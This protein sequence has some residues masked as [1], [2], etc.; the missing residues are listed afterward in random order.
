VLYFKRNDDRWAALSGTGAGDDLRI[1][2][3]T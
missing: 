1:W 3:E 2:E